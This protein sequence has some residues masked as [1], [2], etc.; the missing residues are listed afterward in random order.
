M[1]RQGEDGLSWKVR[2]TLRK[3]ADERAYLQGRDPSEVVEREGNLLLNE[4]IQ[5]LEDLLIGAGGTAYNNANARIG[6]GDSA[7]AAAA[8]QTGLQAA[9]NKFFKAMDATFPSRAAQTISWR[10]T[11]AS[12]EANFAWNEWTIVNAADDAGTNLNRK[13][14]G[15][16]TKVSGAVWELKV[17]VSIS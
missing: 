7:A 17:S 11:F 3:W 9:V 13:A 16:G 10:A 4:G 1:D 5:L 2:V 15:L 14:E 6:V 8:T 12:G